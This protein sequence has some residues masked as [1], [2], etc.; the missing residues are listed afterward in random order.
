[1][2]VTRLGHCLDDGYPAI[3]WSRHARMA[4]LWLEIDERQKAGQPV[5]DLLDR[6][7]YRVRLSRRWRRVDCLPMVPGLAVS[8]RARAAFEALGVPGMRFLGFRVNGEPFFLF[9]TDRQVDCLDRERSD[10]V[11]F[12][13]SPQRVMHVV[14]Y[15]FKEERLRP[16]DVFTVPELSDGMFFWS[17]ETFVTDAARAAIE[18]AALV[19]L[20][21]KP[22][23]EPGKHADPGAADVTSD[24]P[25]R[26]A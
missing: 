19:G 1:V 21:F 23:P 9:Y 16:C 12:R 3:D 10:V 5:A 18:G 15:S 4:V 26:P 17:Q 20:R 8:Q 24:A 2:S 25:P 13:S 11:Y 22:L 14:G 6:V 7:A